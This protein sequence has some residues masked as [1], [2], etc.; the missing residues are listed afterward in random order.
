MR[1]LPL[2]GTLAA[3]LTLAA[4]LISTELYVRSL[5]PR[6]KVRVTKALA[7][8]FNADVRLESLHLS[9]L[10]SPSVAGEGLVVQHRG[11]NDA[12]PLISISRFTAESTFFNLFFQRDKVQSVVLDGLQIHVP[13]RGKSASETERRDHEDVETGKAG[14]DRSRLKIGIESIVADGTLL[15]IEPKEPGKDP[16]R[17]EIKGLRLSSVNGSG[18]MHFQANL[19][20][21]KPPGLIST[22]GQFGPWQKDDPRATAVSGDYEFSHADLAVFKGISGILSSA[23]TYNGVLQHIEVNGQTDTPDFALKRGGLP[24]HLRTTFQSVV[25]GMN[26][27]TILDKVDAHFLNSEFLC[28]GKVAHDE[29]KKGKTV[30]L[31]ASTPKVA[32]M[33]DI[34]HLVTGGDPPLMTGGVQ[35]QSKI[36]IPPGEQDVADRLYLDGNF[37]VISGVFTSRKINQ[38]LVVLSHRARGI[39]KV[40]D[41][42]HPQRTVASDMSGSFKLKNGT[43]TFSRLSFAVPGAKVK[44]AGNF[45]LSSHKLDLNGLFRME[46]TLSDTQSGVKHWLLKPLDPIFSKDGAGLELPFKVTGTQKHPTLAVSAFHHTFTVK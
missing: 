33:E 39:S 40:E 44:L 38:K 30:S 16:M 28:Q 3:L 35:F 10:P 22:R 36:V 29:G 19:T 45:N 13:H 25:N 5:G 21:P 18:P 15:E 7:E 31:F 41:P 27:D 4:V 34:L 14:D 42:E 11:W 12:H 43:M 8:R 17:F 9:L 23:G 24:V 6:T 32:R 37:K 2:Y 20:N 26:G 46:A 1:K